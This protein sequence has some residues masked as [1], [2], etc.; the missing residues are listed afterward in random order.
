M[1]L[2]ICVH[3][4]ALAFGKLVLPMKNDQKNKRSINFKE[5]DMCAYLKVTYWSL[6]F[7]NFNNNNLNAYKHINKQ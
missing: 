4:G 6:V 5:R 2:F 3:A 1:Y 7:I